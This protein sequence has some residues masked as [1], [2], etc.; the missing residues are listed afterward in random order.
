MAPPNP[1]APIIL[2]ANPA[3]GSGR[4][5][6]RA[7]IARE[8]L[9]AIGVVEFHETRCRGDETRIAREAAARGVR[10]VVVVGGDGSVSRAARG[11]VETGS[12]VPL[13]VVA[14]GTGND[15]AKSLGAPVHD[16]AAMTERVARGQIRRVDVGFVDDVPFV[17]AA[18]FGF[19][20]HVLER[21]E[22]SMPQRGRRR[23]L[24]GTAA[25]VVTALRAL[26]TYGGFR[27]RHALA[28]DDVDAHAPV[29]S[30]T[31]QL[32]IVFA[33]G[34]YF[35]GA[36]HIAPAATL[37]SGVL[38]VVSISDASTARRL[39]LFARAIRG[40]HLSLPEVTNTTATDYRVHFEAPP[41]FEADGELHR[42][43]GAIV[44]VRVQPGAL[45]VI[46]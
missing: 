32:M 9:A 39:L 23:V 29:T 10:A 27:A 5:L 45:R 21:M 4:A 30:T 38:H 16:I 40:A 31:R 1:A 41:S 43:R 19:D 42:A 13:A 46:V 22:Q 36:F 12:E 14:A 8:S 24:R 44:D 3:A 25:Y 33:N 34:R 18:G 15:F 37:S 7:A 2:L 6:A 20:V 11:L 28:H 26:V 35:G 17:N